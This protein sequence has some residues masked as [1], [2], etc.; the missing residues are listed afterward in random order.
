MRA[1]M[2]RRMLKWSAVTWVF[3]SV[4]LEFVSVQLDLKERLVRD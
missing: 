2:T 4:T 1:L 3:V